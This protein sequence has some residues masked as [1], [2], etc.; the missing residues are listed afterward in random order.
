[1]SLARPERMRALLIICTVASSL[2]AVLGY[3]IGYG[4]WSTVGAPLVDLYGYQD[5]FAAYQRL[6]DEWGVSII[7]AKAL[8]PVPFKIAAIAAGVAAMNPLSFMIATILGRALHFAMLAGLILIFGARIMTLVARYERPFA[9]IS[10]LV[11]IGLGFACY[12]R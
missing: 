11:L 12:L 5:S 2:G 4:L 9:V 10:L 7:V 6:I 3:L 8:T 1:M